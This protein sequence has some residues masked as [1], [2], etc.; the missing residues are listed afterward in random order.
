MV[1]VGAILIPDSTLSRVCALQLIDKLE[2][3]KTKKVW[4]LEFLYDELQ[5]RGAEFSSY[6]FALRPLA[7]PL[8]HLRFDFV[9]RIACSEC[10]SIAALSPPGSPHRGGSH[11][12]AHCSA[13]TSTSCPNV[14]KNRC[15]GTAES[16]GGPCKHRGAAQ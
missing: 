1:G 10:C 13:T 15:R 8:S 4:E 7:A 2:N 3:M 16:N 11:K 14:T 6:R 12:A 5:V 9:T